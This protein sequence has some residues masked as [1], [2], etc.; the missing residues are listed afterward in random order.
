MV[1]LRLTVKVYPREQ[2][3]QPA[4]PDQAV[5]NDEP[6]KSTNFLLLVRQ[7]EQV[8]LGNLAYMIREKWKQLRPDAG[9]LEIKKLVDDKHPEDS[10]DVTLTAA[11]VFVD[12]GKALADGLDQRGAI[13]VIQHPGRPERYGS[14]VQDWAA[15]G[16]NYARPAPPLFSDPPRRYEDRP[17]PLAFTGGP[18]AGPSHAA[19]VPESDYARQSSEIGEESPG[20][21]DNHTRASPILVE[22]SQ[23]PGIFVS[24][25]G[26]NQA[27]R[28]NESTA[29]KETSGSVMTA[30]EEAGGYGATIHDAIKYKNS[31]DDAVMRVMERQD[32]LTARM[33]P[34]PTSAPL[35]SSPHSHK[36]RSKS[37][38]HSN[39]NAATPS[40]RE[41]EAQDIYAIPS[42]G[43]EEFKKPQKP[44]STKRQRR[45]ISRADEFT[46]KNNIE[47]LLVS[48]GDRANN[49]IIVDSDVGEDRPIGQ[50][51]SK[52]DDNLA[53]DNQSGIRR[54]TRKSNIRGPGRLSMSLKPANTK[55]P[56]PGS[57]DTAK[58]PPKQKISVVIAD[59][60]IEVVDRP[61]QQMQKTSG[62]QGDASAP[63]ESAIAGRNNDKGDRDAPTGENGTNSTRRGSTQ[64]FNAHQLE[65]VDAEDGNPMYSD[66][67]DS[68]IQDDA[69]ASS[70]E[71]Q[72]NTQVG[73]PKK[74]PQKPARSSVERRRTPGSGSAPYLQADNSPGTLE[75][76]KGR[77]NSPAGPSHSS[78]SQ[79]RGAQ[80][81]E[82]GL[83]SPP[84]KHS[85][86]PSMSQPVATDTKGK[87][88]NGVSS[89]PAFPRPLQ[90]SQSQTDR[91]GS[92]LGSE[93][94]STGEPR[95]PVMSALRSAQKN[96]P[97]TAS[98]RRSVSFAEDLKPDSQRT[99][100]SAS[101]VKSVKIGN[102]MYPAGTTVEW[103]EWQ[104]TDA[105]LQKRID[106]AR[107][108]GKSEDYCA[109]LEEVKHLTG[110]LYD[111]NV[112][113]IEYKI[114]KYE[115]KL[116]KARER[117]QGHPEE[118][119][120]AETS[121]GAGYLENSHSRDDE[122]GGKG[123]NHTDSMGTPKGTRKHLQHQNGFDGTSEEDSQDEKP[124]ANPPSDVPTFR[125]SVVSAS[126][127]APSTGKFVLAVTPPAGSM[128]NG[129]PGKNV[130]D[131][132]TFKD[133]N[134]LK[135]KRPERSSAIS[136]NNTKRP[137]SDY[138][139]HP[140]ASEPEQN[141]MDM[142][143]SEPERLEE[144]EQRNGKSP[145]RARDLLSSSDSSSSDSDSDSESD[146]NLTP[147]NGETGKRPSLPP[148]GGSARR[149]LITP[150]R[151]INETWP[152]NGAQWLSDEAENGRANTPT[153]IAA[154]P[155]AAAGFGMPTSFSQPAPGSTG[156]AGASRLRTSRMTMNGG[157]R[158]TR[159]DTLKS[160]LQRQKESEDE[161]VATNV[162]PSKNGDSTHGGASGGSTGFPGFNGILRRAG[163]R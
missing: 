106:E 158:D 54:G 117:L 111:A 140:K 60:D 157:A 56:T 85:R 99:P 146:S 62:G 17:V 70:P 25:T 110:K 124:H 95:T 143:I 150:F 51:Q 45:N 151:S 33:P 19:Q 86:S 114:T 104:L 59:S 100:G 49:A 142:D 107:L 13:R 27:L 102:T 24:S 1:L 112:K 152:N 65:H 83:T 44:Q 92:L 162:L 129:S 43:R 115:R 82:L 125:D 2:L 38:T 126:P 78:P 23:K 137:R 71:A 119:R 48:P 123:K 15:T 22:D 67:S 11:D 34:P 149:A 72:R 5:D 109:L 29:S 80:E 31:K 148:R 58:T 47:T 160:L 141:N 18:V 84:R 101:S 116:N 28:N 154:S 66:I 133:G 35:Q 52:R 30:Q 147:A 145:A 3:G 42:S 96:T 36:L 130:E 41:P 90:G 121:S 155:G 6:P 7:P 26:R 139:L 46:V 138:D 63:R 12:N 64:R 73:T 161:G 93:K 75:L 53:T 68:D 57:T 118:D 37:S 55:T 50:T 77:D 14:V 128:G 74:T 40:K 120:N 156:T 76:A 21:H 135:R 144:P 98:T 88:K 134:G 69:G 113:N 16:S 97:R 87:S 20:Q 61:K 81:L 4:T 159:R 103:V 122:N 8:M 9:P 105:K 127:E 10:L 153:A 163:F 39:S 136:P 89:T 131:E 94:S 91:R 108:Q 79:Q 32:S 132:E